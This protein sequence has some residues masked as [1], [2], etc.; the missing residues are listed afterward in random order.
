MRFEGGG[1]HAVSVAAAGAYFLRRRSF[2]GFPEVLVLEGLLGLPEVPGLLD[3]PGLLGLREGSSS[4]S[5]KSICFFSMSTRL[6][7]MLTG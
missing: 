3:L 7:R 5:S 1:R 4:T 6:T 2:P